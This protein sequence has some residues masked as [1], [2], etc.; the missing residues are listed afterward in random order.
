MNSDIEELKL[1]CEKQNIDWRIAV[2]EDHSAIVRHPDTD[3][4]L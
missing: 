1:K 4:A 2:D 3:F